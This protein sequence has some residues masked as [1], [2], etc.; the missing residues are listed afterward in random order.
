M[1]RIITIVIV[2][3][4]LP[5]IAQAKG[6]TKEEA[7]RVAVERCQ[8]VAGGYF[9][10]E[11]RQIRLVEKEGKPCYY[12]IQF[13]P[14]G[15]ALVSADDRATPALGYS[16]AGCF[17]EDDQPPAMQW[18]LNEYAEGVKSL[19]GSTRKQRHALWDRKEIP[20][21]ASARIE[22]FIRVN[23]TSRLHTTNI[24]RRIP[25]EKRRL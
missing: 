21:R 8:S 4:L 5:W 7:I 14:E 18:W 2:W 1:K 24:A 17:Y 3:G 16:P 6:V 23:G 20:T 12:I 22:P 15:W 11:V 19:S 25:K 9:P 10:A 13:Q